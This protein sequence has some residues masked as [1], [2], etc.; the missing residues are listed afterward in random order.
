MLALKSRHVARRLLIC[1]AGLLLF[2][3][4]ALA[5]AGSNDATP[6][7]SVGPAT[8]HQRV[9]IA[10]A[11]HRDGVHQSLAGHR[12]YVTSGATY[13]IVC[14]TGGQRPLL[15]RDP[16]WRLVAASDGDTST[17]RDLGAACAQPPRG[18]R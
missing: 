18:G 7:T 14:L 2:G 4:L 8:V 16:S 6:T 11:L 3:Y 10:T 12:V 5:A 15:H 1:S 17:V 13:A 9:A